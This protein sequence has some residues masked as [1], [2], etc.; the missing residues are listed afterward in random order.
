[1]YYVYVLVSDDKDRLTYVGYTSNLKRRLEEHNKDG[2]GKRYTGKRK[3]VL[4]YYEAYRSQEDARRREAKLKQRGSSKH[5]LMKRISGS[6][7]I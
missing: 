3:W 7:K 1:M 5:S 6:L 4:V 2:S